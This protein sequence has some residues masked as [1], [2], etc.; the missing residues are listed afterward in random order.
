MGGVGYAGSMSAGES[1]LRR[2]LK[3]TDAV[4]RLEAMLSTASPAGQ[5]YALLG[6]R[7]RDRTA[8]ARALEKLQTIDAKVETAHGCLLGH[9]S[10]RDL[11]KEIARGNYD[12]LLA[13]KWPER[14]R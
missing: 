1:A 8:Y 11:V 3:Q 10:F 6:L 7:A 2:I 9:E 12:A 13:R 4:S 14:A 5:L